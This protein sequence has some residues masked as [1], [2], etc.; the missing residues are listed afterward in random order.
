MGCWS[1]ESGDWRAGVERVVVIGEFSEGRSGL[2][3]V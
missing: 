1:W 2:C 3:G